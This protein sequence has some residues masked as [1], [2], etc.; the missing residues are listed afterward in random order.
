MKKGDR[1]F[2]CILAAVLSITFLLSAAY[3][4]WMD[5]GERIA[6]ITQNEKVILTIDLAIISDPKVWTITN[7]EGD[8]NIISAENGKIRFTEADCPDLV[9]VKS[10]WL[11]KPGDMAVCLPHRLSI[12]IQGK[13]PDV[14]QVSY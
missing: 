13:N 12:T 11:S 14:D 7:N 1:L 5:K 8:T 2:I 10:G 6:V 3:K 4:Y 9:C